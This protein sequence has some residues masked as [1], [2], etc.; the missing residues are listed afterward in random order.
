MMTC[1]EMV[2]FLLDFTDDNLPSDEKKQFEHHLSLCPECTDYLDSY[3][4]TT[5]LARDA[6][7]DEA[8][9]DLPESL[10]AAILAARTAA[11]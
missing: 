6:Y 2:D 11:R 4:A 5:A 1:K 9:E 8:C 10:V 3:R 7:E